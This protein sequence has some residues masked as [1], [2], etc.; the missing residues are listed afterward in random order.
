MTKNMNLRND[1]GVAG[2]SLLQKAGS[3]PRNG[4]VRD[5]CS[6]ALDD[7]R[8]ISVCDFL[9]NFDFLF[10]G[11]VWSPLRVASMSKWPTR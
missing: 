5:F 11:I 7:S 1:P 2:V 8:P 6:D 9:E 4:N 10:V 3:L